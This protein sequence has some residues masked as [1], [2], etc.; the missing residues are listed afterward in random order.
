MYS[1]KVDFDLTVNNRKKMA[2]VWLLKF[3]ILNLKEK[4]KLIDFKQTVEQIFCV[5][6][7]PNL[8]IKYV[9]MVHGCA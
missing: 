9:V 4:I 8:P 3:K 7:L 1:T 6:L 2:V 5:R